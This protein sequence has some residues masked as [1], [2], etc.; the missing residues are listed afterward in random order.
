MCHFEKAISII[1]FL[2]LGVI[3]FSIVKRI[4]SAVDTWVQCLVVLQRYVVVVLLVVVILL[5]GVVETGV[6]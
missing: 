1:F 2:S 6:V 3:V 5:T 4:G